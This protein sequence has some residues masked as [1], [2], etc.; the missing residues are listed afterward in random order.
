MTGGT[1]A[2]VALLTFAMFALYRVYLR[3]RSY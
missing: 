3:W 1:A 2:F